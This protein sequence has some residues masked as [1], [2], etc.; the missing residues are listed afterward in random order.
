MSQGHRADT[1]P[2]LPPD[3][4]TGVAHHARVYD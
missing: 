4:N 3:V 2:A 1:D